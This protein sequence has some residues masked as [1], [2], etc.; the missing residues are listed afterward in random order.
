MT[1]PRVGVGAVAVH[2]GRILLIRRGRPPAQGA[3][4]FPGGHVDFGED[5]H[6]AV[7]REFREET[8]LD[9]VVDRFLGWVERTGTD[10]EPYHYVILDFAVDV[11]DGS[12]PVP[13]DDAA[14]A[15]WFDLDEIGDLDLVDGLYEFLVETGIIPDA[16]TFSLS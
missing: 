8:G 12:A 11:Y 3:W 14:E 9:G 6:S 7:L 13:G 5:L 15:A 4:S 1:G 16:R 2:D 10:P